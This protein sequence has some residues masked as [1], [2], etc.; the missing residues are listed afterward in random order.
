MSAGTL[1]SVSG[2]VAVAD[3]PLSTLHQSPQGRSSLPLPALVASQLTGVKRVTI[4]AP[5]VLLEEW[6]APQ[7]QVQPL[8]RV[9]GFRHEKQLEPTND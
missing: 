7:L 3:T 6:E 8:N 4:S 1:H 9:P 5:G 2:A